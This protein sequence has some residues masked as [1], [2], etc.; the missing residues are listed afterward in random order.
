MISAVSAFAVAM[1]VAIAL[2]PLVR[3]F[4]LAVGAVDTPG[5]RRVNASAIPRLG[6]IAIAAAFFVPL[7]CMF[8][9]ETQVAHA[10]FTHPMH[11]LGLTLGGLLV[12]GLGVF[13]DVS[14]VRAWHKL[15]VQAAAGGIA[16]LC[17]YRLDAIAL[18]FVGNLDM[19]IFGLPV[20]VLWVVTIINAI[21]LIDG[22]DGLAGGIAFFACITNFVVAAINGDPVVMLLSASLGGALLGFLLYNFNPASIFMGDSGSMFL[23]FVLATTSILGNSVKSST[24]VAILA[25]LI[26]LGLPI[27]DTLFAMVRRFLERRPIFAADR[28]HIHHRLLAM[29]LTH[30]RAVLLL[31]GC[32]ITFTASAI[33]VSIG[34]NWQVGTA[35]AVLSFMIIGVMRAMGNLQVAVR[36]WRRNERIRPLVVERMRTAV[37]AVLPRL[38]AARELRDLQAI[39]ADFAER[40][41]LTCVELCTGDGSVVDAFTWQP[42][43]KPVSTDAEPEGEIVCASYPLVGAGEAA[44]VHFSWRA[45]Q[46]EIVPEAEILLQLI[47]D[48]WSQRLQRA[49]EARRAASS[50]GHLRPVS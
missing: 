32:S 31:Y 37:P 14:G 3:R 41:E 42:A 43:G 28:G 48:V 16:Y 39:V 2:T 23:G 45:E 17:G 10:F 6:G 29:G 30:R 19:G 36:R 13:D 49:A 20:T 35:L 24:T 34:R 5:G 21:N 12:C 1:L 26:A 11:I 40:I 44:T 7:L 33:I 15:W 27:I 4:A 50:T 47:V 46:N 9:F 22:L 25:P 8:A 18:P 38:S